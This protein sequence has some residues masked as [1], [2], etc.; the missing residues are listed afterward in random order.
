[1][2]AGNVE[3]EYEEEGVD[4]VEEMDGKEKTREKSPTSIF[5]N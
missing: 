1:M 2:F 4:E 3:Q 5:A